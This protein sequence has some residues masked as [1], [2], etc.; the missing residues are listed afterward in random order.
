MWALYHSLMPANPPPPNP[1]ILL[2]CDS[3]KLARA[4][5]V[6]LQGDGHCQTVL[7]DQPAPWPICP[8]SWALVLLAFSTPT[9]QPLSVLHRAGLIPWV[10]RRPILIIT[11]H[12]FPSERN[13]LIWCLEFPCDVQT[14]RDCITEILSAAHPS[15]AVAGRHD[16]KS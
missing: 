6:I 3:A 10:G 8:R 14:L 5:E 9:K 15:P 4:I 13:E 11:P 1:E 2:F 7:L 16:D 12:P